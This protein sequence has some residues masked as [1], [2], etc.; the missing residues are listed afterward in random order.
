MKKTISTKISFL[1]TA[2]ILFELLI[3]ALP[4]AAQS[5]PPAQFVLTA[6]LIPPA[7]T[8]DFYIDQFQ[9]WHQNTYGQPLDRPWTYDDSARGAGQNIVNDYNA[10]LAA[11]NQQ[12]GASL[13]PTV[14][15]VEQLPVSA[16]AASLPSEHKAS[17]GFFSGGFGSI[18]IAAAI[19]ALSF[20]G[21]GA[22]VAAALTPG[23]VATG[24]STLYGLGPT[25]GALQTAVLV[26]QVVQTVVACA[27]GLTCGSE[28]SNNAGTYTGSSNA[29]P[30]GSISQSALT[31]NSGESFTV[32]WTSVN[33]NGCA[34]SWTGPDGGGNTGAN[35]PN[36]SRVTSFIPI[37]DYQITNACAGPGGIAIGALMHKVTPAACSYSG[38][39]FSWGGGN[40]K[41][42]DP[43]N[44]QNVA[45]GT[46]VSTNSDPSR[47]TA[48]YSGTI[49]YR[50]NSSGGWD[51]AGESCNLALTATTTPPVITTCP[52]P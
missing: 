51:Y 38:P 8:I 25:V 37:G 17:S 27:A 30:A 34:L 47:S 10:A 23:S 6:Q 12:Y 3:P 19:V 35:P 15:T 52:A 45:V 46:Q 7:P 11:Y 26:N 18:L 1:L 22:A 33:A 20:T 41:S 42:A 36:D 13:Q 44:Y 28:S 2:A 49:N 24:F 4:V 43:L 16:Y 50:C 39:G 14:T 21:A 29:V 31:T 32:S 48:G 40:C 9:Q 5:T